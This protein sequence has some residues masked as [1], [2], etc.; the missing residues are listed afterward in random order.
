MLPPATGKPV[1]S[2][3]GE[4]DGKQ[5]WPQPQQ[6]GQGGGQAGPQRPVQP[7]AQPFAPGLIQDELQ[8]ELEKGIPSSQP[9]S[10]ER[11]GDTVKQRADRYRTKL[12]QRQQLA[13]PDTTT[14]DVDDIQETG[15]IQFGVGVNEDAGLVGG[16]IPA[17]L[18]A[19]AITPPPATGLASLDVQ[20]PVRGREF[21]FTTP[22]GDAQITVRSISTAVSDRLISLAWVL[23]VTVV[24]LLAVR[25][26]RQGGL[27]LFAGRAGAVTL[28]VLGIASLLTCVLPVLGALAIVIGVALY[29]RSRIRRPAPAA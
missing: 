16:G 13:V 15:R 9:G 1:D 11:Q 25:W 20:I 3:R 2:T 28:I 27:A 12:E 4:D 21:R 5:P 24:A 19:T 17:G 6:Q 26:I 18:P 23:G 22:R 8:N 14:V 29:I 10:Y 7:P